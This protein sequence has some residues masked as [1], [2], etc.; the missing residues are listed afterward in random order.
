MKFKVTPEDIVENPAN[1]SA[2]SIIKKKKLKKFSP[3]LLGLGDVSQESEQ[4]EAICCIVDLAGFTKFCS[5][6]DPYLAIPELLHGFLEWIYKEILDE[7][8]KDRFPQGATLYTDLPM[9][10]KF[11]G[12]GVLFLWD[13][14]KWPQFKIINLIAVMNNIRIHYKSKFYPEI[15]KR[16]SCPPAVLRCGIARGHVYSV[17][18]GNDFVGPCINIASRLQKYGKFTFAVAQRG[19]PKLDE[20]YILI[21]GAIRGVSD[22]ENIYVLRREFEK[23]EKEERAKYKVL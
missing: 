20:N 2:L 14:K 4:I 6:V 15:L 19:V 22:G 13:V 11:L 16:T 12:D 18:D 10:S 9:M 5:Q 3:V 1:K 7:S 23:L 8:I 21:S 17:G